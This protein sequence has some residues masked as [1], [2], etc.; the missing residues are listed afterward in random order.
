MLSI[1]VALF[2]VQ[3]QVLMPV[4][5]FGCVFFFLFFSNF[6]ISSLVV[7]RKLCGFDGSICLH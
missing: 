6:L 1:L 4:I 7:E 3:L 2:N 5:S